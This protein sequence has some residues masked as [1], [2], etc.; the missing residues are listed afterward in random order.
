MTVQIFLFHRLLVCFGARVQCVYFLSFTVAPAKGAEPLLARSSKKNHLLPTVRP[1][2]LKLQTVKLGA[3]FPSFFSSYT[4][5]T[6]SLL[7]KWPCCA[8][9]SWWMGL[10]R[11]TC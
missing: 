10:L 2:R 9:L 7:G 4:Y 6:P 8:V 1:R 5:D 11:N 3:F